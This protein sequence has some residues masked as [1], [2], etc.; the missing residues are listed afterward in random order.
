[1][2]RYSALIIVALIFIAGVFFWSTGPLAQIAAILGGLVTLLG[3][4]DLIQRRHTLWRNYPLLS[5]VRWLAEELRPFLR[6]YIVESETEGKPFNHEDRAMIYRRAKD[7]TSVEPFGS[8]LEIDRPPY[9]WLAHSI[10]AVHCEDTDPR[11]MVGAPGTP[12]PYSASIF[13][14]SAMSFGSLGAHAIEALSTGAK[15]G[16]FYHDTGEGSVSRYHRK[17]GGDLV[18]ELGSGYFGCRNKDGSFDPERFKD[19]A[20][21]PQIKMIEIKLSQGAKP[22]HGGVL[23]GAKVTEAIAEARGVAV[24]ETCVSPPGHSAF[25]TP[26]EL[27]EFVAKLR[28]MSG[29]KPVG[30]KFAVGNRWEVLAL[31]KAMMKTGILMDFMV[32][33][34]GEGGTGAA[35]AEFLDHVGAPLRPGLV[36]TRNALVGTGLKDK[37]RLAASGKQISAFAIASSMALGADWVNSARGFMFS[38]GCIQSMN[39]HN[40]RC[41]TGI[42]TQDPTRQHGLDVKDKAV[43]VTNFHHNTVKAL[44]EVVG[45]AGC[46]HPGELTPRHIMHRVTEDI[47]RPADEA[48]DLLHRGQLL[49]DPEG[50]HLAS[51]WA[52]AQ[53]DSFKPAG[54]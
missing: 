2:S 16:G 33:D 51:E 34:G 8:H 5:R 32:V 26:V 35:P 12:K 40:N 41:P 23:P 15:A 42:A 30:A 10:G 7:V 1:M 49:A 14:I 17:G 6:S 39:C 47:V 20:A 53:A 22:G 4:S 13:N 45:A 31:C 48:Y 44:M 46:K 18:W 36:L 27:M 29:G 54:Y 9:E 11:V 25:S 43:R 50:T 37:V 38:L 52:M 3:I 28:E 19:V 24:G 21:D